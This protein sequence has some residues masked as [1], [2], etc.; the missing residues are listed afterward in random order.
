MAREVI[1]N[2]NYY[3]VDIDANINDDNVDAALASLKGILQET[4]DRYLDIP[5][6]VKEGVAQGGLFLPIELDKTENRL[7]V[8]LLIDNGGYSMDYHILP[9]QTLFK[10][11]KN[12]LCSRSGD[13]LLPQHDLWQCL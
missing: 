4:N 6:T 5:L 8:M 2:P 10:K 1:D 3:P 13:L 12:A 9:V 7:Q 11:M